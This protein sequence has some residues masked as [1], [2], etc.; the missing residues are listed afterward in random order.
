VSGYAAGER[1]ASVGD[2]EKNQAIAGAVAL[3][4]GRGDL[5]DGGVNII[6]ADG[7]GRSHRM[8]QAARFKPVKPESGTG[9][10]IYRS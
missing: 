9:G 6:G 5:M 4:D 7:F 10:V 3:G 2:A 1:N 8:I